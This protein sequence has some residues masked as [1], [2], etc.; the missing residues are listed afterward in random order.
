MP[1]VLYTLKS[2]KNIINRKIGSIRREDNFNSHNS[3]IFVYWYSKFVSLYF[4][5]E[6]KQFFSIECLKLIFGTNSC[7]TFGPTSSYI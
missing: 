2:K 4:S 6:L 7:P 5:Y 3:K 1:E